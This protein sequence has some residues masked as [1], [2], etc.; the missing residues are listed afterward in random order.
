MYIQIV[1]INY[2]IIILLLLLFYNIPFSYVIIK[3][4]YGIYF[5]HNV[6]KV[7]SINII[8][9]VYNVFLKYVI[10]L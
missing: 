5:F 6:S 7:K 10:E 4:V 8:N 2:S 3:H 1:Y 9:D